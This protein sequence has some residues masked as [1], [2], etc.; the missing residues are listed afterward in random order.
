MNRFTP[1]FTTRSI[2][3][4]GCAAVLLAAGTPAALAQDSAP[5]IVAEQQIER[6]SVRDVQLDRQGVRALVVNH[7]DQRLEDVTLRVTYQWRWADEFHPGEDSPGFSDT[8]CLDG[9]LALSL[10]A[11]LAGTRKTGRRHFRDGGRCVGH[12]LVGLEA[13]RATVFDQG[14]CLSGLG[15]Q[16]A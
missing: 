6:L 8:V 3:Q 15:G 7:S 10:G 13:L 1:V 9:A 5:T 11:S 12:R 14:P 16:E 4:A 2:W